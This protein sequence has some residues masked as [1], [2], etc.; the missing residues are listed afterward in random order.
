M[1]KFTIY[2]LNKYS[3]YNPEDVFTIW[4]NNVYEALDKAEAYFEKNN[5]QYDRLSL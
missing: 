3:C 4:A 2:P 5:I 1:K